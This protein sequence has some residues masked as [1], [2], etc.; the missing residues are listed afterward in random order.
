ME[1]NV[2]LSYTGR[3]PAAMRARQ[4][5]YDPHDQ[6]A[7]RLE[8]LRAIGHNPS[9]VELIIQG[10]TFP[11]APFEYQANFV[12]RCLDAVN[13]VDAQSLDHAKQIAESS[14]IRN[15]GL[16]I[17]T[18]PDWAKQPHADLMLQLGATRVEIGVQTIDDHVYELVNRGHTVDD[19][20]ESFRIMK[21]AAFKIVAH[22]M[23]GLPGMN[24]AKDLEAFRTLLQDP[25]FR[26]D[27]MK[28]Y[29]C[30][31]LRGTKVYDWWQRG[32]Y[33]PYSTEQAA[34]LIAQVKEFVPS[35][36]RIMRVQ[37]EIPAEL[38]V[39][40]PDKGNLRELALR[41][42]KERGKRCRCIRCREVGHRSMKERLAPNAPTIV[43]E[44][45]EASNGSEVFISV[46]DV[47]QD[48][49][50]GYL[51]LRIPSEMAHRPEIQ[52]KR[53]GLVREVHV[54]GPAV[55]VGVSDARAWQHKGVGARLLAEAERIAGEEYDCRK[56]V[57]ISA[58]GTKQYYGRFGYRHDGPYVSKL[59]P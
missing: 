20:R 26:P 57:V 46:E 14:H 37:R 33:L 9:K 3:E 6:I 36:L 5:A 35:W 16:T 50:I 30:L 45:Y 48:I 17:E 58:L 29:P 31:V 2:P 4:H 44:R 19:V 8:Q 34:E 55:P 1:R 38:I 12:K 23:P 39:A 11:A 43:G 47:V 42:L 52:G 56:I 54:Y 24:F 15:V 25:D 22:M 53:A 59:I 7:A 18:K 40:G 51:R 10:G 28:I 32:D 49:L 13:G 41:R 21:D 27:M